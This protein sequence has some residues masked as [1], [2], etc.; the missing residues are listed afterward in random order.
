[1]LRHLKSSRGSAGEADHDNARQREFVAAAIARFVARKLQADRMA[2]VLVAGDMNVGETDRAKNGVKLAV[3]HYDSHAGDLYDD[4]HAIFSAGLIDQLRMKSLTRNL[5]T[6]TYDDAQFRGAGPIDCLYVA[7]KRTGDFAPAQKSQQTFGSDHFAVSTRLDW[8]GVLAAAGMVVRPSIVEPSMSVE[9]GQIQITALLPN[10]KGIDDG[11]EW[12]LLQNCGDVVV[13][14][15]GWQLRDA[16][17]NGVKLAG[18]LRS[19]EEMK[20]HLS[21]GQLPLNNNGDVIHLL[22]RRGRQVHRV[23]YG[24]EQVAAGRVLSFGP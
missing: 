9:T 17:G 14:L 13:D 20:V 6:E 8:P 10:P 4:T 12:V 7:G 24:G 15:I 19:G 5:G 11:N 23:G 2:T 3:D 16:A 22:D 1:M 21:R 18:V